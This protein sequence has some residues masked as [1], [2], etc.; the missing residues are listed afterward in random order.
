MFLKK[1]RFER[2]QAA[3]SHT[4]R[5]TGTAHGIRREVCKTCG[6]VRVSHESEAVTRHL[7]TSRA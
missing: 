6:H 1:A 3:C 5:I 2:R 7:D 4:E